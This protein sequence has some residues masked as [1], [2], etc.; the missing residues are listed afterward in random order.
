MAD[1]PSTITIDEDGAEC[2]SEITGSVST[3]RPA[4]LFMKK[5]YNPLARQHFTIEIKGEN[6]MVTAPHAETMKTLEP[7]TMW[8]TLAL[9]L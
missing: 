2:A 4:S 3:I 8:G 5:E 6:V 9:Y 7:S 1:T